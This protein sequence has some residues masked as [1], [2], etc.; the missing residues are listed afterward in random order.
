MTRSNWVAT[1]YRADS[2]LA[3]AAYTQCP[4]TALPTTHASTTA[5]IVAPANSKA[6]EAELLTDVS[7][8]IETQGTV[9]DTF[10][11][12]LYPY[13]YEAGTN[14]DLD[15]WDTLITWL[16]NKPKL[17]VSMQGGS[18]RYPPTAGNVMPVIIETVSESVNKSAGNHTVTL[19][20]RVKGTR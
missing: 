12:E 15:D 19:G 14:P 3:T 4:V 17:W 8:W 9:R 16:T 13:Q 5:F 18:R 1:F 2:D 6:Y 11:V 20:L 10:E 7:G